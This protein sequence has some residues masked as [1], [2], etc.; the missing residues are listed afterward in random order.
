LLVAF[1]FAFAASVSVSAPSAAAAAA[2]AAAIIWLELLHCEQI[3]IIRLKLMNFQE[4]Q[5]RRKSGH[6]ALPGALLTQTARI[7]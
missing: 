4:G 2:A 6:C 5:W 1:V 3:R 7:G